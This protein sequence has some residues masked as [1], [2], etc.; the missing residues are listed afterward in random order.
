M[1]S[2]NVTLSTPPYISDY[3]VKQMR[4]H[5]QNKAHLWQTVREDDITQVIVHLFVPVFGR[6]AGYGELK[7]T[8]LCTV[9]AYRFKIADKE[10]LVMTLIFSIKMKD[11]V[12]YCNCITCTYAQFGRFFLLIKLK[13]ISIDVHVV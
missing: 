2:D 10:N 13:R 1:C 7:P 3:R 11:M 4:Q 12:T 5:Q 6:W 9:T 8:W